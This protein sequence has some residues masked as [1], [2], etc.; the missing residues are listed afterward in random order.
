MVNDNGSHLVYL[1]LG[2]NLGD[3]EA[4][5]HAA[6]NELKKRT[7]RLVVLSAFYATEPWGFSSD[8]SFLNAACCM[9]TTLSPFQV[10]EE[11]QTIERLLGRTKKSVDG[12][13]ADRL[14]DIDLLL[15][16]DLV[17]DTP[18]LTIPHPLMHLRDFVL[19]PMTEIAPD[20]IHPVLGKKIRHLLVD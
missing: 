17:I 20:A 9:E 13:Y 14:I 16:D 2:T 5:L 1:S 12:Q 4:N 6:V 10:L 7:G 15:F 11:T 18:T 19:K 8:H 3:K